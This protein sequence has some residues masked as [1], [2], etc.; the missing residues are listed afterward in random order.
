MNWVVERDTK[1]VSIIGETK[2][3]GT[4]NFTLIVDLIDELNSS[5]LFNNAAMRS[6]NKSGTIEE[7]YV[8]FLRLA[9][10]LQDGESSPQDKDLDIS[11]K[12]EILE[13]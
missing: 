1:E 10:N 4:E 3:F 5:K 12:P 8:A 6:F 7:G 11:K 9:F 13:N 2:Q